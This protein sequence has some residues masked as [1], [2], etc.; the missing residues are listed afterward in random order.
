MTDIPIP[1]SSVRKVFC[2]KDQE[3]FD[4]LDMRDNYAILINEI[5]TVNTAQEKSQKETIN[6]S[7]LD[8]DIS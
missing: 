5:W 2:H 3:F 7:V 8:V 6:A 4:M 1:Q